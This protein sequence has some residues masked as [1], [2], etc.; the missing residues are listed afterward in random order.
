VSATD[1]R[2]FAPPEAGAVV[3]M[4]VEGLDELLIRL[5]ELGYEVKG[6]TLNGD[7]IVPGGLTS[8]ADFPRGIHDVQAP[9]SYRLVR[10]DDDEFFGWA[11]G[12]ESWKAEHFPPG[13]IMWRSEIVDGVVVFRE[14][15]QSGV[16]LAI[17]GARPCEAMALR[18]MDRVLKDGDYRDRRYSDRRDSSFL[19]VVECTNA[20]RLDPWRRRALV[21]YDVPGE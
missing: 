14:P 21:G 1:T 5:V 12:P 9:G 8:S 16:P 10:T 4:G 11:V 13:Q 7:A 17:V 6:P 18:V 3:V 15:D 2:S 19:V 20:M